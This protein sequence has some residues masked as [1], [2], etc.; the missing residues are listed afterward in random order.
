VHIAD[1][2]VFAVSHSTTKVEHTEEGVDKLGEHDKNTYL[3]KQGT[4]F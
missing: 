2:P 3:E 4:G 1:Q